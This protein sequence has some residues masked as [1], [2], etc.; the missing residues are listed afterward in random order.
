MAV[1]MFVY[2]F[3][4]LFY[5]CVCVD[6]TVT[7]CISWLLPHLFLSRFVYLPIT[8]LVLLFLLYLTLYLLSYIIF[9]FNSSFAVI[10]V[11]F[12]F[13]FFSSP[14]FFFFTALLILSHLISFLSIISPDY[15]S[16]IQAGLLI[17]I[18][19]KYSESETAHDIIINLA[20]NNEIEYETVY[21]TA[22]FFASLLWYGF[23][24]F[25][26]NCGRKGYLA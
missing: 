5:W 19:D 24:I 20:E 7:Y 8:S 22:E 4:V 26:F 6:V 17:L 12:S 3:T 10:I 23:G 15:E 1:R 21:S 13:L 14:L 11:Y 9:V 18:N 16:I 25:S 2:D